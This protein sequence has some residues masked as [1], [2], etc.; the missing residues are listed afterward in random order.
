MLWPLNRRSFTFLLFVSSAIPAAAQTSLGGS[1]Q[2][3]DLMSLIQQTASQW[4]GRLRHY[5]LAVF[6]GLA[7]IQLVWTFVPVIFKQADFGEIVG[8]LF[9]YAMTTG[10][11][12]ALLLYSRDW[13]TALVDSFRQAAAAA[14]GQ[15]TILEPGDIFYTAINL[16]NTIGNVT[17]LNPFAAVAIALSAIIVLMSFTFIAG[18]MCLAVIESYVVI[19]ASVLF[20]GFGGSQWTREYSISIVRYGVAVGAKLF[21]LTLLVGLIVQSAKE[22]A[23][24]YTQDNASMWTMV[25]LGLV[26]A[27]LCKTI[28]DLIQSVINGTSMSSGHH[29]GEMAS[30]V[31]AAAVTTGVSAGMSGA[32]ASKAG[33]ASSLAGS[34]DASMTAVNETGVSDVASMGS[35]DVPIAPPSSQSSAGFASEVADFKAQQKRRDEERGLSNGSHPTSVSR[36]SQDDQ[37]KSAGGMRDV[38]NAVIKGTGLMAS[39]S[40]PGMASAA[41]LSLGPAGPQPIPSAKADEDCR[42]AVNPVA[43]ENTISVAQPKAFTQ[44]ENVQPKT[45][46]KTFHE[47]RRNANDTSGPSK[48]SSK[49]GE[50]ND[51]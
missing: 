33:G 12:L 24:A 18:F 6:W 32:A 29:I 19:N 13:A 28:P 14:T 8:E 27:Y 20:M 45:D 25:G 2:L 44:P 16:A 47:V 4:D 7:T 50:Q 51:E 34:I 3:T 15:N 42:M 39:I 35:S 40:V 48:T 31:A 46:V 36:G 26:C 49:R 10:F 21:V 11:F 43:P 17:T 41:S 9:K 37:K 38:V 22:W 30:V 23:A 1:G 5:A